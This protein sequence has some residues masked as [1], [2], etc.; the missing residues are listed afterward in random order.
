MPLSRD[1]YTTSNDFS[2]IMSI[3]AVT[4][5][6]A[7]DLPDG[8]CRALLITGAGSL[9]ITTAGG[10]TVTLPISANWFGVTY[11]RAARIHATG[12]TVSAANIFACY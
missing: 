5:N 4:P 1:L 2:P 6:D 9:R 8:A 12:T 10:D 7:A 11:I 3:K